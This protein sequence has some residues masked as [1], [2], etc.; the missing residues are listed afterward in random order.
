MMLRLSMESTFLCLWLLLTLP[1]EDLQIHTNVELQDLTLLAVGLSLLLPTITSG[2][3]LEETLVSQTVTALIVS[4]ASVS[5]QGI[6][7]CS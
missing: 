4:V 6:K 5:I 3:Q 2:F 1:L 7:I